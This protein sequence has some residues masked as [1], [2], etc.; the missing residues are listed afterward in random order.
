MAVEKP[1]HGNGSGSIR[2]VRGKLLE[3]KDARR[4]WP[5]DPAGAGWPAGRR[6]RARLVQRAG[7]CGRREVEEGRWRGGH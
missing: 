1:D 6:V 4:G 2:L 5:V 3:E 7:G